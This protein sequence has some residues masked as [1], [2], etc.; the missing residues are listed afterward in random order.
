MTLFRRTVQAEITASPARGALQ[1]Q[2][3]HF[4]FYIDNIIG[5]IELQKEAYGKEE[6]IPPQL[7]KV[8][9]EQKQALETLKEKYGSVVSVE[10]IIEG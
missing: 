2:Y 3:K 4:A 7:F 5:R 9:D 10:Q 6:N 1:F 8:Y